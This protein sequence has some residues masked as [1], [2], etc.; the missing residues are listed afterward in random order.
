MMISEGGDGKAA[1]NAPH[2]RRFARSR[3]ARQT[4][5]VWT[6]VLEHRLLHASSVPPFPHNPPNHA[7]GA[8]AGLNRESFRSLL[9]RAFHSRHL[10]GGAGGQT[11]GPLLR[12]FPDQNRG[13]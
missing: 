13:G 4:R 7:S 6:A 1:V 8:N 12:V 9:A 2:S 10:R 3:N 5:S 11:P